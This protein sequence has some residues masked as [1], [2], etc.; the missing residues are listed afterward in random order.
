MGA[1]YRLLPAFLSGPEITALCDVVLP[2]QGWQPGRQ[3]TGDDKLPLRGAHLLDAHPALQALLQRSLVALGVDVIDWDCYLLRYPT[4]AQIP[5]HQDPTDQHRHLRL[6]AVARQGT[7]DLDCLVLG[8]APVS[9]A[10]ADAVVFRPYATLHAVRA[11]RALR[12]LWSVGCV[13]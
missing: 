8:D 3:G 2:S 10:V 13:Y 5:A 12:V 9:L 6:N 11:V 1:E 7:A 4:G